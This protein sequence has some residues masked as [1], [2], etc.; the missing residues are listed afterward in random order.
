MSRRWKASDHN[1]P[2]PLRVT[3]E[4]KVEWQLG[5]QKK[6]VREKGTDSWGF[7]VETGTV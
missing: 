4:K 7:F 1:L 5:L 6:R 3:D 2:I